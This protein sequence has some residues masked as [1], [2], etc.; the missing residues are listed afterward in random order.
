MARRRSQV[1]APHDPDCFT[2]AEFCERNRIST[3][4]YYKLRAEGR[5]PRELR[6]GSRVLITKEDAAAWRASLVA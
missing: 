2:I 3:Q 1:E 5:A 6:L 4:F